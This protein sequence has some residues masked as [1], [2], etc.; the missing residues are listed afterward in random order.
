MSRTSETQN[1]ASP[2]SPSP[3]SE[4]RCSCGKCLA[5]GGSIKCSRCDRLTELPV[6]ISERERTA[7]FLSAKAL[8][9]RVFDHPHEPIKITLQPGSG[10]MGYVQYVQPSNPTLT[11]EEMKQQLVVFLGGVAAERILGQSSPRNVESAFR[12]AHALAERIVAIQGTVGDRNSQAFAL[13]SAAML[14][15]IAILAEHG[16]ELDAL[17]QELISKGELSADD[18]AQQFPLQKKE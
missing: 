4:I 7:I 3:S 11:G 2:S 18:I 16:K 6:P 5:K 12:Q 9:A 13:V 14:E 1:P 10:H 8:C 17:T 15:A